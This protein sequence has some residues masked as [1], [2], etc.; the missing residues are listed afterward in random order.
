MNS[1][2]AVPV[3]QWTPLEELYLLSKFDYCSLAITKDMKGSQSYVTI[4]NDAT[5]A[6]GGVPFGLLFKR[7]TS[8]PNLMTAFYSEM[9]TQ[10]FV[11]VKI[12]LI[13]NFP[14]NN[15]EGFPFPKKLPQIFLVKDK[16]ITNTL[17]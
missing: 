3:V 4:R 5:C 12:L 14:Q 11:K 17:Y 15:T 13:S 16:E 1:L 10:R 2:K 7:C 9:G 8:Y 6:S